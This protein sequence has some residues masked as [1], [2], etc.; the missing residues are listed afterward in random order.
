MVYGTLAVSYGGRGT[1]EPGMASSIKKGEQTMLKK[2]VSE[3]KR[4]F[5]PSY[6][7]ID[8]ICGCY[9]N[10][11]KEIIT[12]FREAFLSIPEDAAFKYYEIFKKS[13]SGKL[14]KNLYNLEFP[15]LEEMDGG[16]QE[17]LMQ[18]RG[19]QLS[20]DDMLSEMYDR[21]IQSYD[22]SGN[23]LIILIHGIYDIPGKGKDGGVMFDA[24]EEV[25]DHILCCICP[26]S[27]A[28]SGLA[29]NEKERCIKNRERDWIVDVPDCA[30]LFPSF[31]DRSTDIHSALFYSK[32][33]TELQAPVINSLL[34]C[35]VPMTCD[36]Q[37]ELFQTLVEEIAGDSMDIKTAKALNDNLMEF[38]EN[39]KMSTEPNPLTKE[40]IREILAASS[41][42]DEKLGRFDD[43]FNSLADEKTVIEAQN[44][45]NEAKFEV[46]TGA[47]H[48]RTAPEEA[49][50]LKMQYIDGQRCLVIELNDAVT[51]NG[52]RITAIN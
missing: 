36:I 20:D 52:I 50:S 1:G 10:T 35:D 21:I 11:D 42:P 16:A 43:V 19:S 26:M 49:Q 6:C 27:L 8:R 23:F 30:F 5:Q 12:Q 15:L 29:Y 47:W 2:E 39:Q 24:S 41:L 45:V 13:L 46:K 32:S 40:A 38:A 22:Y 51:V 44:V 25:Y 14:G 48:I 33:S 34:G 28:K 37:K 31:N 17:F 3:I 9:V 4:L 7:C 18:L